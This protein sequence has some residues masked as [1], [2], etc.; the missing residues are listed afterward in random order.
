MRRRL[1]LRPLPGKAPVARWVRLPW[2]RRLQGLETGDQAVHLGVLGCH[3]QTSVT[4]GTV[5]HRSKMPLRTAIHLLTSHSNGISAEQAQ[6]QLGIGS[7]K[8]AWLLLHKLRRAMVNPERCLLMG[9]VEVDET[10]VPLR[11]KHDPIANHGIPNVGILQVIAR[12]RSTRTASPQG[13]AGAA[14]GAGG[15]YRRER[16][17]LRGAERR[18]RHRRSQRRVR[19]LPEAVRAPQAA[20]RRYLDE[21]TFRWNRRRHTKTAFDTLLAL[22]VRLPHASMRD[23]VEQRV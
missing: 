15:S 19:G 16:P 12:S 21:F 20:L 23:F 4:A 6:A 9:L 13:A 5:M 7:H 3:R 11:S 10:E 14:G 17:R 2:L 18:G 8:I 22:R 1:R